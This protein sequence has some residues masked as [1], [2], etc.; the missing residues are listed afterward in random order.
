MPYIFFH[1]IV[2]KLYKS[3]KVLS[4]LLAFVKR[5]VLKLVTT[6]VKRQLLKLANT[7]H[8]RTTVRVPKKLYC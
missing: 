1:Y 7:F 4:T 3:T 6:F 5:K 2:K 8:R